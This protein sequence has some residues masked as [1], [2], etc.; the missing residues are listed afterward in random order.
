MTNITRLSIIVTA[1]VLFA[2]ACAHVTH[3]PRALPSPLTGFAAAQRSTPLAARAVLVS[4]DPANALTKIVRL[5]LLQ[6][7]FSDVTVVAG[8]A[9]A[10][11]A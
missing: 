5:Q 1:S 4:A 8:G 11:A 9:Q 6:A 3:P 7:G 2:V 10:V